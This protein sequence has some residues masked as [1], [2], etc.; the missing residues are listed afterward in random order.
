M[1]SKRNGKG[2]VVNLKGLNLENFD[3]ISEYIDVLMLIS[4]KV[5]EVQKLF[6]KTNLEYIFL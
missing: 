1:K 5:V 2:G 4:W 3:I 6:G